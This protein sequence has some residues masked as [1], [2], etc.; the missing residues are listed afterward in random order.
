M[1]LTISGGS[2]Y[3]FMLSTPAGESKQ[4]HVGEVSAAAP[5]RPDAGTE[6][7]SQFDSRA[8]EARAQ[9]SLEG[10]VGKLEARYQDDALSYWWGSGVVTHTS[11]RTYL[12]PPV[13]TKSLTSG[14]ASIAGFYTFYHSGG[15]RYD[16]CWEGPRLHRR[17]ASNGTN[18]W[19]LVYT[20]NVNITD[21]VVINGAGY[22]AV[23]SRLDATAPANTDFY[24]QSDPTAAATWTPTARAHAAFSDALGKPRFFRQVRTTTFA[25]VDNR[26]VFYSVDPTT[27]AWVGPIDTSLDGN[28]SGGPGDTTYPFVSSL[29]VNDYLFVFKRDAAYNIDSQQEVTEAIWQWK[30]RPSTRNFAFIAAGGETLYYSTGNEVWAY[31]PNTGRNVPVGLSRQAG[32]ST[33]DILGVG[34]DNQYVYILAKVRVPR[35][36]SSASAALLRGVRVAASEWAFEVLWEDTASTAYSNLAAFPYGN[37][38]RVYWAESDG[39]D[40]KHMDVPAD[41]DE[42][43]SGSFATGGTL[44]T[45]IWRTGFPNNYKRWLW[46]GLQVESADASNTV[47]VAYSTDDG[48]TW[49]T[50][51]TISASGASTLAFSNVVAQSMALRFTWVCAGTATPVLR[52]YDLHGRV[53]TRY[54]PDVRLALRVASRIELNN[55]SQDPRLV[56]QVAADLRTLRASDGTIAY[57]DYLGNSFNVSVDQLA[58][59]PTRHEAPKDNT[60]LEAHVVL[61]RADSGS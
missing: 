10:G 19:T 22:I 34:A 2:S 30:Q 48:A 20:A 61:S 11:G 50:L 18:A 5:D 21:F 23:P 33:Q 43:T 7:L 27:D 39:T 40:V 53:R 9:G 6:D 13:T 58:F 26:K 28:T 49:T 3:G 45:S 60:E 17:D 51:G 37:G 36:R 44:Y 29:A 52:I 42:T 59:L 38:T 1:K 15:T 55:R 25:I 4:L 32:Y 47:A 24:Y 46:L 56:A 57:E 14:A 31:D 12:A 41:W 16:F 54:L 8:D 35:I